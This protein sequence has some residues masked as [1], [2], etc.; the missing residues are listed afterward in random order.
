MGLGLI[1]YNFK[2]VVGGDD[3]TGKSFRLSHAL[4]GQIIGSYVEQ[5]AEEISNQEEE[6]KEPLAVNRPIEQ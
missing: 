1:N 4:D 6:K 5:A 2:C 3:F